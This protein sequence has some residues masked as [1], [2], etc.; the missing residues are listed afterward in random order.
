[1]ILGVFLFTLSHPLHV[2]FTNVEYVDSSQKWEVSVKL[3]KDDFAGEL[4]KHF[5]FVTTFNDSIDPG[6]EKFFRDYIDEYLMISFNGKDLDIDSWNYQG[7]N[8]NFEAVWL[9]FEFSREDD[10]VIV[11]VENRLM[12]NMFSDQKNLLIF[13]YKGKQKAYQFRHNKPRIDFSLD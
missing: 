11:E 8:V 13:T 2:T 5:G 4:N 10:P 1:M 3:F 12:F 6:E 9:N 7:R